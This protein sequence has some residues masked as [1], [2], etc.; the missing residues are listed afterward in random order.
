MSEFLALAPPLAAG[1]ILGA[2]FFGGLWWT[3]VKGVSSQ[4]PALWFLGSL[5]L[6]M[7]ITLLG[8][9]IV[10]RED[11]RRWLLCVLG[12]VMARLVTQRLARPAEAPDAP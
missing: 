12:F 7:S 8:F 3:V 2:L 10:A 6:R 5:M 9:Y 1:L 4:R 11:W